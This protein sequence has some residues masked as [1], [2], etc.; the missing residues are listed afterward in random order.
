MGAYARLDFEFAGRGAATLKAMSSSEVW[1]LRPDGVWEGLPSQGKS[2]AFSALGTVEL[3][4]D[5]VLVGWLAYE[6]GS[7]VEPSVPQRPG[8]SLLGEMA[9]FEGQFR[10]QQTSAVEAQMPL[11]PPVWNQSES[12]FIQRVQAAKE[13]IASGDFFQVNLSLMSERGMDGMALGL[14]QALRSVNPGPYNGLWVHGNEAV[15]SN[16]PELLLKAESGKLSSRPIAGTFRLADGESGWEGLSRD[17]K[18]RAEHVMLV[19]LIRNDLG[20]VA[21]YGSV[22]VE[23]LL[24]QVRYSHVCHLESTVVADL[25]KDKTV[26]DALRAMFPGGTITGTPKVAAMKHIRKVEPHVR[27]PYTGTMFVYEPPD[28]LTAN[29]LIRTAAFQSTG[30]G[31]ALLHIGAGAGIVADSQ[32][33]KEWRECKAKLAQFDALSS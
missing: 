31:K 18:E 24:D 6:A 26:W 3:K 19:D 15:V 10:P 25:A 16:S 17:P 33:E 4:P 28:R 23:A 32:P 8:V 21:A 29:I 20:R 2:D 1:P 12:E 9:I 13:H 27:G 22:Q 11:D 5:Q 30:H 7:L 14:Y